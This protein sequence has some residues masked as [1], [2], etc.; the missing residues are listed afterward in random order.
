MKL[1][2]LCSPEKVIALLESNNSRIYK[3]TIIATQLAVDN[4]EL[5]EGFRLALD[6]MITFGVKKVPMWEGHKDGPGLSWNDFK[7][8]AKQLSDRTA[9]GNHARDEIFLAMKVATKSQWDN[10]YRRILIK[11]LRCG[12]SEKTVNNVAKRHGRKDFMVP[13]FSCQL[14]HDSAKHE[15]KVHGKKMIE[16]KLDG[17][18]VISIVYPNGRVDQYSRNGKELVNFTVIKDQLSKCTAKFKE[19]M[20][21]DGEVMSASF[22]DLMTQVNRKSNVKA[23]DAILHLFD[24]IPLKDFLKGKCSIKQEVRT[25]ALKTWHKDGNNSSMLAN[26]QIL[27][28]EIVDLNTPH[29]QSAYAKIN[30][31]AI[32]G[33]YEGI[34]LKDLHA[35][36]QCKRS[37]AWL[38]LKP[39]IEVSLPV[40]SVE[41]GTGKNEGRLGALLCKGKDD[42][43]EIEVSVGG[44]YTDEQ[45][46]DY[47][48]QRR[49]LIGM[50]AEI[51]ADTITQNKDGS[52]SLRFP[53]FLRFRGF[54]AGEKF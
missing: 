44:G 46:D 4:K 21:L 54:K 1:D 18:R 23:D 37:T 11:D 17:V 49:K 47:W 50:V 32:K 53:R 38:K 30:A 31:K 19:P 22:Q 20:V 9:T 8:L 42:G 12:V 35:P 45:R 3:E 7:V 39:F 33:G 15:G 10:W 16:V 34:M 36:Y 40:V 6:S 26:V 5:F 27:E 51:R 48:L 43:T 24:I 28:H 14:A 25:E 52:Y 13:V 29:G 2:I 41:E